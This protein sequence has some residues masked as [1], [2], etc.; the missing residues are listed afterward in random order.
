MDANFSCQF[1]HFYVNFYAMVFAVANLQ[2]TVYSTDFSN[3][4]SKVDLCG[5]KVRY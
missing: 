4:V 1:L 2:F 5:R 3:Q